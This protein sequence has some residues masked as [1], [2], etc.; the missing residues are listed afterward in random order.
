MTDLKR[1]QHDY[2][3]YLPAISSFY[4]KQIQKAVDNPTEWRVPNGFENGI[5]GLNFLDPDLGYFHYPYGL[6]SAGHAHLDTAKSDKEEAM[7]Q[8]RNRSLTTLLG[9]SGGFQIATG[10]LKMNWANAKDQN[11]PDRQ[12]IC[13]KILKWL[14]HTSDWAMTL[15]IPSFAAAPPYSEKTGLKSFQDTVEISFLNLDYFVRNRRPGTC[16]FLNVLSGSDEYSSDVW[17]NAVKHF[18]DPSWVA[19]NYGDANR[20]L[21]G[22]AFA[23]INMR[24][25]R[26]VL[27]RLLKLREDGLLKDK[28][29]IHF[30]GTGR[31]QWACHLTSIQRVLRKYDSPN[32]TI[33]FDAAS[34]FVNTAYGSTYAYN[35]FDNAA[36][37][38]GYYMDRAFDNQRWKNSTVPAPFGHSPIMSRLSIG[39]LCPMAIGDAD[40]NG[41]VKTKESTSWDTLSYLFYMGHSVFNHITAVQEANRLADIEKYRINWTYK[42]YIHDKSRA[43]TNDSSPYVPAEVIAFDSFVQEVL[44]PSCPDPHRLIDDYDK[45]IQKINFGVYKVANKDPAAPVNLFFEEDISS[46][47][48]EDMERDRD[49][50]MLDPAMSSNFLMEEFFDE[51]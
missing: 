23:G 34:P 19:D 47:L 27:K 49:D 22:Y 17:Y 13:D 5:E 46:E 11:D 12:A 21:E 28:G 24:N 38:F 41:K 36:K 20:T 1:T 29:W 15:D 33:S 32:I 25:M 51:E 43:K 40:R 30:L 39:D 9:D 10:V 26:C 8:K 44:D 45:L 4:S 31:L 37:R 18:S 14:E 6:Y 50:I 16:K 7:V 35:V 3:V 48:Y 42:D 2:A